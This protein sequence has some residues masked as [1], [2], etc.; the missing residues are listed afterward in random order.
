MSVSPLGPQI[1]LSKTFDYIFAGYGAAASL[2]ILQ[3]HNKNLLD[4]L[5]ILIVDPERKNKNDKTFCFWANEEED[6]VKDLQHLIKH[7]WSNVLIQDAGN[8]P[9]APL[10]YHHISSIDLYD[11]VLKLEKS[12][13]WDRLICSVEHVSNDEI[14]AYIIANGEII[15]GNKVF[16]SRTPKYKKPKAGETHIFQSFVGW[17]IETELQIEHPD[18]CRLMDFE[19]QQNGF[20]QFMYVL[21]FSSTT[22]LVE[23]TRFGAE[24]LTETKAEEQ[25]QD[26]IYKHFGT[27]KKKD[28]E[29]GCIPMSN[30]EI[31]NDDLKNV[32]LLG[33]RNYKIKPST[34]Y[35]FKNMYLHASEQVKI[36]ANLDTPKEL[37]VELPKASKGRF[38]FYDSLLLHILK[39]K[40]HKGKVIF[41]DLLK[42]VEINTVLRFLDEKTSFTEDL[43]IFAKLPWTPFLSALFHKLSNKSWFIPFI[44]ILICFLL[45]L[46][47][48]GTLLQSLI[49]YGLLIV[50]LITVGIPHGAVDHLHETGHWDSK[51]APRFIITYLLQ[52]AAMAFLW[53]LFPPLALIIFLAYSSWHFGQADGK[54]WGFSS[55]LSFIW[56]A[57]LLFYVLGTHLQET[58]SITSI[59][60]HLKLPIS[61]PSWVIIPWIIWSIIRK[62]VSFSLTLIWLFLSSQLPLLFAFGLYFI[63]QHSITSW[64]HIS[65]HLKLSN[66]KIWLQSL[67]FHAGAWIML[68]L[69]FYFYPTSKGFGIIE[70]RQLGIFFI[71]I[72]CISLPHVISMQSLYAK[73]IFLEKGGNKKPIE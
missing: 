6:I 30:A 40:P 19:V 3:L 43:K 21:P 59:I 58:N 13:G 14:G 23:L 70:S 57:F 1:S 34:G 66:R 71:F 22:A 31:I 63:G 52:A 18:T 28:I 53:Y 15:R 68:M 17:E 20:T 61:F 26:Y 42:N 56:G 69:F 10:T 9:L 29:I 16:D 7:T 44:L 47:G 67:P 36:I 41:Q 32:I 24:I 37:N 73:T 60:G 55:V 48:K 8:T 2:L 51:K 11:E 72:A 46:L 65:A 4:K 62:Q 54:Q 33:A 64:K 12:Y 45:L 27:F 50:G 5:S 25:L 39:D 35:A 49:G 38:A